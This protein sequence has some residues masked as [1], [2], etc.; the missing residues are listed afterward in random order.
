MAKTNSTSLSIYSG[1]HSPAMKALILV[2]SLLLVGCGGVVATK[3]VSNPISQQ[4]VVITSAQIF[5]NVAGTW[6]FQNGYGDLTWIEKIPVDSLH[7]IWHYSKNAARAYWAPTAEQAELWFDLE[8]DGNGNWYSTG[9][10]FLAPVGANPIL[11][12]AYTVVTKAG[13]QRPYLIMPAKTG[14]SYSTLFDDTYPVGGTQLNT[15]VNS[16]WGTASYTE[17]VTTPLFTGLAYVSDQTEGQCIHEKWYF[18][19]G[20]GLV[21]VIPLDEGSCNGG[22][23]FDAN[24]IMKRIA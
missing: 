6:T 16:H 24:I 10:I 18:A 11:N 9:G 3:P 19:P 8:D 14:F 1:L 7:T 5:D 21:Q 12:V 17:Q 4:A 13:H 15:D 23:A 20:L 2:V 22:P